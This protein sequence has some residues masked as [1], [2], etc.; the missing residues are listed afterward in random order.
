MS[1][2]ALHREAGPADGAGEESPGVDTVLVRQAQAASSRVDSQ[3]EEA[4]EQ[5]FKRSYRW[6]ISTF[7]RR[8]FVHQDAEELAQETLVRALGELEG[9]R[10]PEQFRNWV[11]T[12]GVNVYRNELRRRARLKRNAIETPLESNDPDRLT[13][14]LPDPGPAPD[15]ILLKKERRAH[16]RRAVASLSPQ[17]RHCLMLRLEHDLK[18]RE[19]AVVMKVSIDTV[20]AHLAQARKRLGNDLRFDDDPKSPP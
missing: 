2:E 20:K 18:Y 1:E 17:M 8:G 10:Q 3:R 19:I 4:L 14:T 6:V 7:R 5:L 12:I 11:Y 13:P 9:L 15:G 16:L